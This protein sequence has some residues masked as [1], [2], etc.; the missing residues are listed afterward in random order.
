MAYLWSSSLETGHKKIDGQH[1]QL[2]D[3]LNIIANASIYKSG[4]GELLKTLNFLVEYTI[5]HFTTEEELMAENDYP[6]F[7]KHKQDHELFKITVGKLFERFHQEGP[8]EDLILTV[9]ITIGD[10]LISH[11]KFDD[12]KMVRY[13]LTRNEAR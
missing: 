6:E 10:W 2:F 3:T 4:A 8:S 13:I 7:K 5:I 11:I 1:R 12:T 9:T